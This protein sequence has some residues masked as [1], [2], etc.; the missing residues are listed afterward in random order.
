MQLE[1]VAVASLIDLYEDDPEGLHALV[2]CFAQSAR[3]LHGQVE[4]GVERHDL[5]TVGRAA[6]TLRSSAGH[7]GAT[8]LVQLCGE[9]EQRTL[10]DPDW[11]TVVVL[12][13]RLGPAVQETLHA[14]DMLAAGA[15][16]G[17]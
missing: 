6:H 5:H 7:F 2:D 1:P 4:L 14:V 3:E 10:V 15:A 11:A 13:A 16:Q 17:K 9:L 12:S 8:P